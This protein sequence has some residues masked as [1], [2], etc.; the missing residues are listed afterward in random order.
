LKRE[1]KRK[2]DEKGE[3]EV[4]LQLCSLNKGKAP[5]RSHFLDTNVENRENIDVD[6]NGYGQWA[7]N[8]SGISPF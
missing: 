4:G 7:K 8:Y 2:C 6:K 3:N 5:P 1:S